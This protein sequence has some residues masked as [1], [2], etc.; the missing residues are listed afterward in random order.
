MSFRKLIKAW[1][2]THFDRDNKPKSLQ[3]SYN[4]PEPDAYNNIKEGSIILTILAKDNTQGFQLSTG[5]VG[6]FIDVLNSVRRSLINESI[7]LMKEV[8]K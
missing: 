3:I 2:R 1:N 5:D 6:D 4:E 7:K 8:E